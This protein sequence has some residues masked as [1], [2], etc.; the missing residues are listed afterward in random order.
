MD[1]ADI[2]TNASASVNG[3]VFQICAGVFLFLDDLKASKSL[4]IE[5]KNQ[6]IEIVKINAKK[7]IQVKSIEDVKNR[8]SV[9]K[10]YT[11]A[12]KS[13]KEVDD[14]QTELVY[15]SNISDP[16]N[17]GEESYFDYGTC[18]SFDE[19]TKKAQL[20][21]KNQLGDDF[22]YNNLKVQVVHYF[23]DSNSKRRLV[24][25][26]ISKFLTSIGEND[27]QKSLIYDRLVTRCFE[28]ATNKYKKISKEEF[29]L[30]LIIPYLL[31]N[32]SF[33]QFEK[34]SSGEFY[35]DCNNYYIQFLSS[36]DSDYQMFLKITSEYM[37]Y[38]KG[39]TEKN[40]FDFINGKYNNYLY[41]VPKTIDRDIAMGTVKI[42]MYRVLQKNILISKINKEAGL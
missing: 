4:K 42:L 22:S 36:F 9:Y 25:D 10:H 24:E 3:W 8:T 28:N 31:T 30:N 16:F 7:Y 20:K 12:L 27:S 32:V 26:K 15:F 41:L 1:K 37:M 38:K 5:G 14:K 2:K 23:G 21:I 39:E 34:F 40:I 18:F 11:D 17:T 6:D 33:E 13:L 35:D 29:I 19:L